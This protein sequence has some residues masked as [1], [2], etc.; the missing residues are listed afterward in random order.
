M[1]ALSAFVGPLNLILLQRDIAE[2]NKLLQVYLPHIMLNA[3]T[4]KIFLNVYYEK[5]FETPLDELRA[6]LK[7]T[8]LSTKQ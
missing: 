1:S 4:S 8:P 6:E 7:I 5:H 2:V 3:K